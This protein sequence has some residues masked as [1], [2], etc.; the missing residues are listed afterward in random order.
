ML[1]NNQ[2][3]VQFI[4]EPLEPNNNLVP[5]QNALGRQKLKNLVLLKSINSPVKEIPDLWQVINSVNEILVVTLLKSFEFLS[6]FFVYFFWT[7]KESYKI[8]LQARAI[9]L[10]NA[11]TDDPA[12]YHFGR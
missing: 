12:V 8:P 2:I 10:S 4:Y 9:S 11:P 6:V 1:G 5:T 7:N 3:V